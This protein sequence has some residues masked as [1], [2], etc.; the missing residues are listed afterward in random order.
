MSQT[1]S[2]NIDVNCLRNIVD[3]LVK[4]QDRIIDQLDPNK[5]REILESLT[6]LKIFSELF[7]KTDIYRHLIDIIEEHRHKVKPNITVGT[8]GAFLFGCTSS[9]DYGVK[10]ECNPICYQGIPPN[11]L[12]TCDKQIWV[13]DNNLTRISGGLSSTEAVLYITSNIN[14]TSDH[15]DV[16]RKSGLKKVTVMKLVND[17]YQTVDTIDLSTTLPPSSPQ[18]PLQQQDQDNK[19]SGSLWWLWLLIIL[20]VLVLIGIMVFYVTYRRNSTRTIV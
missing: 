20:V 7:H 13:L 10:Q 1:S 4:N 9:V 5:D 8:I 3:I 11:N 18:Q 16:L 2:I 6:R 17:K 12:G 14:V 19:R 15:L